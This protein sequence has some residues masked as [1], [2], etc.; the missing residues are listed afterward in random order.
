MHVFAAMQAVNCAAVY[1]F[2]AV[3]LVGS[4]LSTIVWVV[5]TPLPCPN[6]SVMPSVELYGRPVAHCM[7]GVTVMPHGRLIRPLSVIRCRSSAGVGPRSCGAN[8]F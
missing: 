7:I 6:T 4:V 1:A 8:Q 2:V 3:K 5:P